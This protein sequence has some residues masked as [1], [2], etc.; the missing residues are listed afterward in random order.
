MSIQINYHSSIRI[1]DKAVMYFDPWKIEGEPHDADIIFVTH[2]HYDHFSPEDILKIRRSDTVIV[3]PE[4][5][6]QEIL[7][8]VSMDADFLVTAESG[9]KIEVDGILIEAVPAYNIGKPFHKKEYGWCGY[10][11]TGTKSY[12]VAGDTDVTPELMKLNADVFLLPVG[13]KYT[14][15]A[16]EAA[17]LVNKIGVK[18]AIPTH[19]GEVAGGPDCGR[20][21]AEL[22]NADTEV[23]VM[24]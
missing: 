23:E 5:A 4:T 19:Y 14:M 1:E 18:K 24:L 7:D 16:K 2:T 3:A 20:I 12:Y 13:G 10:V 22:L 15:D 17:D 8:G 11:V 21:F 9:E 6:G